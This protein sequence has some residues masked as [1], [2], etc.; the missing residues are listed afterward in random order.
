MSSITR[1]D[2]VGLSTLATAVRVGTFDAAARELHVT[3]SAVSQRVKALETRTG[4]VLLHR[5]KPVEPTEAGRV[6]LRLAQQVDLLER[7][8]LAELVE[9][10]SEEGDAPWTH[11]P[12][13]VNADTI[14]TWLMPAMVGLQQRH[15]VT[16]EVL[17]E[18]ETHTAERLRRGDVMAAITSQTAPVAGCRSVRLG[19]MRYLAVATPGHAERWFADG[20]SPT[21]LAGAPMLAFD[22]QDDLQHGFLRRIA[23]RDLT[24]PTTF[25]PAA[26]D[27]D[28]AVRRGL[29]WGMLPESTCRRDLEA[30]RLVELVPGRRVDVPLHWQH[31]RLGS[32]LMDEL[33]AAV[34]ETARA[35]LEG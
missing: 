20:V 35:W 8:A 27:F 9:G 33:T 21:T 1:I 23:R 22:R 34:V 19:R 2:P 17:R 11:V 10:E 7:D 18:D 12:L 28:E 24:P 16:F 13:A 3:A 4:R 29:G 30:G 14:A 26:G 25:I 31:W 15:R 32:R 5:T 6:L